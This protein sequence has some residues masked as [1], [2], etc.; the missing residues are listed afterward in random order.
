MV[1]THLASLGDLVVVDG[2]GQLLW[3]DVLALASE[4]TG[5]WNMMFLFKSAELVG[6]RSSAG[7]PRTSYVHGCSYMLREEVAT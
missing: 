7:N 6:H 4:D 1:L 5:F 3:L 2:E